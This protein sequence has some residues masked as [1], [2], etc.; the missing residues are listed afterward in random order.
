MRQRLR[1]PAFDRSRTE[2]DDSRDAPLRSDDKVHASAANAD[3][4]GLRGSRSRS[5]HEDARDAP[6]QPIRR[7]TPFERKSGDRYGTRTPARV[8]HR[9]GYGVLGRVRNTAIRMHDLGA[10]CARAQ[11][12][13]MR[14]RSFGEM[15]R[16]IPRLRKNATIVLGQGRRQNGD[17]CG[18]HTARNLQA[19]SV[20]VACCRITSRS[21][22][23]AARR[24]QSPRL[25]RDTSRYSQ[26][27]K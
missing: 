19:S 3:G 8:L 4:R 18:L 22:R 23:A 1:D 7:P 16:R 2:R 5:P 17:G 13:R 21:C 25:W 15:K 6:S 12:C 11:R 20:A 14:G 10:G 27:R 9:A 24:R 26:N